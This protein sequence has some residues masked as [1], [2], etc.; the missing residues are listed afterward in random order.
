MDLKIYPRLGRK[1]KLCMVR[2]RWRFKDEY[3][4]HPRSHLVRRLTQEMGHTEEW[5]RNQ[6]AKEREFLLQYPQYF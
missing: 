5:V 2:R 4:Y 6:I 1:S 3:E